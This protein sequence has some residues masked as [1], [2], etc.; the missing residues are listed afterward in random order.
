MTEWKPPVR[1]SESDFAENDGVGCVPEV[2]LAD[3]PWEVITLITVA[4][5][6]WV[7]WA[8]SRLNRSY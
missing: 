7:G 3:Q 1:I 4:G 8:G 5:P 6:G 2:R